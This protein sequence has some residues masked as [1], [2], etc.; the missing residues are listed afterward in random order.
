MF[1]EIWPLV[2]SHVPE[3]GFRAE[4]LRDLLSVFMDCD[5]EGT[6]LR[7]LDPEIDKASDEFGVGTG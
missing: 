5:M 7:R 6:D 4:F 2:R 3:D 1:R